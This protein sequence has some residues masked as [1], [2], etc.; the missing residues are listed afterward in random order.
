MHIS[1]IT[2]F[3]HSTTSLHFLVY[4]LH[5]KTILYKIA[6]DLLPTGIQIVS[7]HC[8]QSAVHAQ[9]GKQ[10]FIDSHTGSE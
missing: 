8:E 6:T 2:M 5:L 3:G 4:C 10:T 1:P 7:C 9:S